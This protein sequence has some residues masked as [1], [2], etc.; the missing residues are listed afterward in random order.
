MDL[1]IDEFQV[2][3]EEQAAVTALIEHAWDQNDHIIKLFSRLKKKLIIL[4]EIK[5]IIPYPEEDCVEALY[6]VVQKRKQFQ[7]GCTKWKRKPAV[8]R[9]AKAQARA[10][11]KD[12]YAIFEEERDSFHEVGV[13]NNAVI[14][15]KM[16]KL[17]TKNVQMKL[18]MADNQAKIE[19]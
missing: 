10:Y 13:A 12:V 9:A 3:L 7:K 15:E 19:K 11:F 18:V 17:T 6:M 2:T 8:D 14:Q 5:N 1:L 4:A 16:D